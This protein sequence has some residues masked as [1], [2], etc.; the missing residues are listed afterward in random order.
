MN[1][2]DSLSKLADKS[3][4]ECKWVG[5]YR[6][7]I[8][9]LAIISV[10][11]CHSTIWAQLNKAS[12][13]WRFPDMLFGLVFTGSFLLLSG[14]GIFFSLSRGG[15]IASFYK[16]RLFRVFMPFALISFP[17]Y[18]YYLTLSE[19]SFSD[20]F[21]NITSLY[22]VVK[23]NNGMWYIT[24]SLIMYALSPFI[25]DISVKKFRNTCWCSYW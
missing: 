3:L 23:S 6:L 12:F 24:A 4:F 1:I 8:M 7:P 15:S 11:Y 19:C 5:D 25:Y 16:R 18:L 20:F 13:V 10:M 14:Y 17:F 2:K 9:G 21:L 22:N